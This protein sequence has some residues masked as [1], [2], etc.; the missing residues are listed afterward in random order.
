MRRLNNSSIFFSLF[1]ATDEM[2]LE[3]IYAVGMKEIQASEKNR[4]WLRH[5]LRLWKKRGIAE[6]IYATT[7]YGRTLIGVKL[8]DLGRTVLGKPV[9]IED[10]NKI[11]L[12]IIEQVLK[13]ARREH[14]D[15]EIT[16]TIKSKDGNR[17]LKL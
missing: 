17:Y 16:F 12:A 11:T 2:F 7:S 6:P 15:F 10:D 3:E 13:R 9:P 5:K 4:E 14:P 1:T 8:T